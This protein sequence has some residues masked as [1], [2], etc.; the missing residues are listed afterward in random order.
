MNMFTDDARPS[1]APPLVFAALAALSYAGVG[2]TLEPGVWI[3]LWGVPAAAGAFVARFWRPA[4]SAAAP[5]RWG[6]LALLGIAALAG[7]ILAIL[8]AFAVAPVA[9]LAAFLVQRTE[10]AARAERPRRLPRRSLH[11]P[12]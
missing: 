8:A 11:G 7:P 4:P 5:L 9:L 6:F 3:A 2:R 10:R 1:A 12:A